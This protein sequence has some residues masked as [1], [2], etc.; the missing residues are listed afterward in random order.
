M[1]PTPDH[2]FDV[3]EFE[4][5][6]KKMTKLVM[7][8]EDIKEFDL[9][10]LDNLSEEFCSSLGIEENSDNSELSN[11]R[12][13]LLAFLNLSRIY[14]RD[15]MFISE[16]FGVNFTFGGARIVE[17]IANELNLDPKQPLNQQIKDMLSSHNGKDESNQDID[18]LVDKV[19]SLKAEN[20]KLKSAKHNKQDSEDVDELSLTLQT[21][22]KEKSKKD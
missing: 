10:S 5:L 18:A 15:L 17:E 21:V 11:E 13:A 19:K 20:K 1:E 14:K 9:K 12:L 22:R 4:D 6:V 8:N 2:Q 7:N 16:S 3:K